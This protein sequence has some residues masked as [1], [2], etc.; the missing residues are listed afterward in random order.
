MELRYVREPPLLFDPPLSLTFDGEQYI[1]TLEA[2]GGRLS[3]DDDTSTKGLTR[4]PT[5]LRST[6]GTTSRP[7]D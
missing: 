2:T 6:L 3:R 4:E 5:P 1:R 7:S